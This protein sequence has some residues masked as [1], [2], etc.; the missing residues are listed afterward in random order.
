V[1]PWKIGYE[2]DPVLAKQQLKDLVK[3]LNRTRIHVTSGMPKVTRVHPLELTQ[4]Q[5]ELRR[6]VK[7]WMKSGPNLRRMFKLEPELAIRTKEGRTTFWPTATGRGHLEWIAQPSGPEASTPKDGA[8]ID[9]MTLITNPEW[10][11]LGGPCARC[12]DYYLKKTRR[13]SKHC[14]RTC[15][16]TQTAISSTKRGRAKKQ[17]KKI[18]LAQE[19]IDQWQ[20]KPRQTWKKWV[21]QKTGITDRWLT[22][23]EHNKKIKPPKAPPSRETH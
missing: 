10:E 22:R 14:S 3:A 21:S 17:E 16:S 4:Q 20:L 15:S 2:P 23:A 12:G 13:H 9:F 19:S 5:A 8:L 7:N 18:R 6:L 1:K 11:L